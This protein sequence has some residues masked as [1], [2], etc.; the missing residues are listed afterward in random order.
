[1]HFTGLV[2]C[3]ACLHT[4]VSLFHCTERYPMSHV[5]C[6]TGVFRWPS[7]TCLQLF[8]FTSVNFCIFF[9]VLA[10]VCTLYPGLCDTG[11][12][13]GFCKL[14]SR[15]A[16]KQILL[17]KILGLVC[18]LMLLLCLESHMSLLTLL[19]FCL[20]LKKGD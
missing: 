12:M 9:F 19:T 15:F 14:H 8:V 5:P 2:N 20:I 11:T 7:L 6:K 3:L 10:F 4:R 1:M 18:I 16:P 17:F 13:T